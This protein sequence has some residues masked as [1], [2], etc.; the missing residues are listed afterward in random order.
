MDQNMVYSIE[1]EK[2]Y[3]ELLLGVKKMKQPYTYE[4]SVLYLGKVIQQNW[5]ATTYAVSD[6]KARSNLIYKYKIE[7]EL[8]MNALIDLPGVIMVG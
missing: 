5:Y 8:P 3:R 6:K 2:Y 7:H 4:G 1:E